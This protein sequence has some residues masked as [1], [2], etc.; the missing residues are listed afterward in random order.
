M[1]SNEQLQS[2]YR[3]Q[4]SNMPGLIWVFDKPADDDP[5]PRGLIQIVPKNP[6]AIDT[7]RLEATVN[8]DATYPVWY[9]PLFIGRTLKCD[10]GLEAI[11][12]IDLTTD[13]GELISE[14]LVSFDA[15]LGSVRRFAGSQFSDLR[16]LTPTGWITIFR[17]I[18]WV[19]DWIL[20][21]RADMVGYR[22]EHQMFR[23]TME[24]HGFAS[25]FRLNY[26]ETEVSG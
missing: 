5:R 15:M 23:I 12:A 18:S 25:T 1:I 17:Y 4:K 26:G 7:E 22:W 8:G 13:D 3:L 24:V 9:V 10:T 21:G 2:D 20:A 6:E 19:T 14:E 16:L 11:A